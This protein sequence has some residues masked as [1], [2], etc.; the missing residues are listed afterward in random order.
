[1]TGKEHLLDDFERT[2]LEAI[3]NLD[4]YARAIS[5]QSELEKV[6]G[7]AIRLAWVY[8]ILDRL[9][10]KNCVTYHV[11]EATAERGWRPI[12]YF[13]VTDD[14]NGALRS[15][16]ESTGN[17]YLDSGFGELAVNFSF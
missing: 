4:N 16:A 12:L 13:S 5:I 11:G 3:L 15:R 8:A 2:M 10:R 1:M 17:I 14:G 6:R 7:K 9:I